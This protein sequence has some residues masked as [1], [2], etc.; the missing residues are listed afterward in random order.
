M[1]KIWPPRD[2][3]RQCAATVTTPVRRAHLFDTRGSI[4]RDSP[5]VDP[6]SIN[7]RDRDRRLEESKEDKS[8][9][10]NPIHRR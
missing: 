2:G 3:A 4:L 9:I 1:A 6:P 5:V 10:T 7:P 8:Q